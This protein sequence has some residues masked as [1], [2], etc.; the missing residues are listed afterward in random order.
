MG[1]GHASQSSL[2]E[3]TPHK[4]SPHFLTSLKEVGHSLI[5]PRRVSLVSHV[6]VNTESPTAHMGST[7]IKN[8]SALL[9]PLKKNNLCPG[10]S[11]ALDK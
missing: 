5:N 3:T 8:K 6:S 9:L 7:K 2:L 4:C 11:P 1:V 10:P